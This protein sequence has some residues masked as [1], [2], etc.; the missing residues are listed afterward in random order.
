M[1]VEVAACLQG[2][3]MQGHQESKTQVK[4]ATLEAH[5]GKRVPQAQG[6][7]WRGPPRC[8]LLLASWLPL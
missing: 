5:Q 1:L 2:R 3:M 6:Y 7:L 8:S 4:E